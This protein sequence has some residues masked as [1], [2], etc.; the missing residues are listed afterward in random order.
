MNQFL[1]SE[2]AMQEFLVHYY[3]VFVPNE[4]LN[5]EYAKTI[6]GHKKMEKFEIYAHAV[7]DFIRR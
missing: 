5:T 2:F 4:Y 1:L 7:E 6:E 3:P